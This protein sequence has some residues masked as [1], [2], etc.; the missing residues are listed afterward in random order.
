L[1]GRY[2]AVPPQFTS[3]LLRDDR[4]VRVDASGTD[5]G[6]RNGIVGR[7]VG[8]DVL[9]TNNTRTV[10]QS[11]GSAGA[12]TADLVIC[13]GVPGSISVAQQLVQTE[14]IRSELRFADVVRGLNIYGAK[15]FRP[16]GIAT[17]TAVFAAGTGT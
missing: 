15:V 11:D 8:F 10:N 5:S 14:A 1:E 7:A 13:A 17:A 16:A 9:G 6:L 12:D 4:F 3:G 2:V